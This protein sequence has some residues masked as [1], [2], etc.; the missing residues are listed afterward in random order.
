MTPHLI[1]N[2]SLSSSSSSIPDSFPNTAH[3]SILFPKKHDGKPAKSS[4][5]AM[6]TIQ[7]I[8]PLQYLHF[9]IP[10]KNMTFYVRI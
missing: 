1:S 10:K 3:F 6:L 4:H 5:S 9:P 2:Q 8:I 7:C